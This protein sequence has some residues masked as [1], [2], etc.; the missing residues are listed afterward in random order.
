LIEKLKEK[1][2][3]KSV[4][5]IAISAAFSVGVFIIRYSYTG[6]IRLRFLNWNLF[7]AA[8]PWLITVSFHL[9]PALVK[10]KLL[11]VPLL[12][13]WILFFP[14]APYIMTDLFHLDFGDNSAQWFDLVLIFS[15]AWTGLLFCFY[16]LRDME[17][18]LSPHLK[19]WVITLMSMAILFLSGLGVYLGRFSRWNSWDIIRNPLNLVADVADRFLDPFSHPRTWGMTILTGILLNIIY[20]TLKSGSF[21]K[22]EKVVQ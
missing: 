7:L 19:Q 13:T 14:N 12:C 1:D 18:L 9:Y 4:I 5:V 10:K 21:S 15:Y 17:R 3:W 22:K 6:S 8:V 11:F 16:S 2:L 20:F